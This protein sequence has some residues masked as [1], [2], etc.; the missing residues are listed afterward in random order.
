MSF[1]ADDKYEWRRQRYDVSATLVTFFP[2]AGFQLVL[3]FSSGAF[4]TGNFNETRNTFWLSNFAYPLY[5]FMNY[6]RNSM[7]Q[8]IFLLRFDDSLLRNFAFIKIRFAG[9]FYVRAELSD[10]AKKNDTVSQTVVL[11]SLPRIEL[12]RSCDSGA[13]LIRECR[14]NQI[15]NV[16]QS[17]KLTKLSLWLFETF[18]Q[19][20]Y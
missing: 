12:L 3:F 14:V 5:W 11:I 17:L 4:F 19:I 8:V 7:I 1:R 13:Y 16:F 10:V 18:I 15:W 20:L 9:G 6:S 2:L